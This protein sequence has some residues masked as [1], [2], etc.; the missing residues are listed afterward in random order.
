[1]HMI[2]LYLS[3][4]IIT[5]LLAYTC[6]RKEHTASISQDSPADTTVSTAQFVVDFNADIK[7]FLERRCSPCHFPGGKMYARMPFD[8]P[9]TIKDHRDGI[10]RRIKD[11]EELKKLKAFL[12]KS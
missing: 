2:K 7:P 6:S 8:D 3:V 12:E 4:L 9:K 5:V 1:M 11:E 10:L